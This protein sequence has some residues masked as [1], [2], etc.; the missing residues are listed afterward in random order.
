MPFV[1]LFTELTFFLLFVGLDKFVSQGLDVDAFILKF[2][3]NK[4][5]I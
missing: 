2:C 4:A 3:K 5:K 1:Q